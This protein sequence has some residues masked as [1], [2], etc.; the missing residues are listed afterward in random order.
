MIAGNLR[1]TGTA[2]PFDRVVAESLTRLLCWGAIGLAV[3]G[4]S[5][6]LWFY[7][8][9]PKRAVSSVVAGVLAVIFLGCL[10][11][12]WVLLATR[13]LIWSLWLVM[14]IGGLINGGVAAPALGASALMTS[15]AAQ[16]FGLG[17]ALLMC[18][19][20]AG[21]C[22]FL[23]AQERAG[24]EAFVPAAETRATIYV[25]IS[26][27]AA[28]FFARTA[29]I[30]RASTAAARAEAARRA[31]SEASLRESEARLKLVLE[32]GGHSLWDWDV[33]RNRVERSPWLASALGFSPETIS[34]DQ[35]GLAALVHPDDA[36]G[37]KAW[38]AALDHPERTDFYTE[39]RLRTNNGQWRWFAITGRVLERG[40]DGKARRALGTH[41]DITALKEAENGLRL[42]NQELE[43]RVTARTAELQARTEEALRFAQD[44]RGSQQAA[45]R[46]AARLQEVNANLMAA[47]QELEAFSYSVS[48]DLR[49]P[50]RNIAGFIELL[51]KRAAGRLD[52]EAERF[53][54]VITTET[55]RMSSL[56]DDLLTFSKIGRAELVREP[57]ALETMVAEVREELRGEI[58]DRVIEWRIGALPPVLGDRAL[59][60]QV[61]A[62]LLGNAVKFTRRR[63]DTAIE[64]GATT[65]RSGDGQATFFV[66]DN[67][68]GFNPKYL[69]KLFG[70]FQRLH[71]ARDFEGTGIGLANVK[72]IVN[73]HGG[74]VWAEG[75]VERG[76]TF[77]F[78]LEAAGPGAGAPP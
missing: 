32:I 3:V 15:F 27:V 18:A 44:L 37:M 71:N 4:G 5:N 42:L 47:N 68:A 6:W 21:L 10:R 35:E 56:I 76:A 30:L 25:T 29:A 13:G 20:T 40:P 72:R 41:T 45:D 1:A 62:N 16:M 75:A 36:T 77:Y 2:A 78:T 70:V 9:E 12:G 7:R 64:F 19:A 55:G 52:P 39:A 43:Q 28:F 34:A 58:G 60:R 46:T 53:V 17:E 54:A 14:A 31:E 74:R 65:A 61:V 33:G 49:A 69:D 24:H 8:D 11:R 73:R 48:H 22:F 38:R 50:L 51:G 23:V 66:R 67:G 26:V 63:P 59:L 57:L